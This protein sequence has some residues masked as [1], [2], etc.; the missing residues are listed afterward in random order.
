[1]HAST[2]GLEVRGVGRGSSRVSNEDE[3]RL[4]LILEFLF[5]SAPFES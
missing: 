4:Q 5:H 2:S 3:N 1:M